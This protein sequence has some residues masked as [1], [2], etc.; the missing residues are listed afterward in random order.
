MNFLFPIIAISFLGLGLYGGMA[1]ISRLLRGYT[2]FWIFSPLGGAVYIVALLF[3]GG[4]FAF[5]M[6]EMNQLLT[7]FLFAMTPFAIFG[8]VIW[9][10]AMVVEL[11]SRTA[12][13]TQLAI[14][15]TYDVADGLMVRGKYDEAA[16]KY[17]EALAADELDTEALIRRARALEKA[18]HEDEAERELRAAHRATLEH[19]DEKVLPKK[20]RQ[21]RLLRL[22]FALGDL[23]VTTDRMDEARALYAESLE[24]LF[25]YDEADA[26]R[27]R[28]KALEQPGRVPFSQAVQQAQPERISLD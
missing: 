20:Q 13:P 1:A 16:S 6:R 9:C 19:R 11:V 22:S 12:G 8:H 26:L 24:V 15:K 21:E 2:G 23:L 7:L 4:L 10:I 28:L 14:E 25:G 17:A 18:G 5:A 3:T 27:A